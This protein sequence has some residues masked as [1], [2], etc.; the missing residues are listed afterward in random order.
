M[1]KITLLFLTALAICF[2]CY[3]LEISKIDPVLQN[4]IQLKSSDELIK[5]NI[6]MQAQ[7]DQLEL[8]SIAS[9]YRTKADKRS[10]VVNELKRYSQETQ[11]EV[12]SYLNHFANNKSVTEITQFWIFNGINCYATIEVIE[13]LSYL[14]DVL[15]I[16]LDKEQNLLP[17]YE[18][19]SIEEGGGRAIT[20]NVIKINAHL[21]WDLG[22]TGEGIIVAVLDSGVN[23]NHH[24]LRD[25]LWE[26]PNYP[27]AG[28]NYVGNNND[29]MDDHGHG[30]HCAGTVASDG[31][32]GTQAGVAPNAKIMA[33]KVMNASG[34]GNLS[35]ILSG[36]QFAVDQGADVISMSLGLSGGGDASTR[37]TFRNTMNNV[38]EAGIVAVVAAGN[39]GSFPGS[40]LYPVPNNIGA[41]A[42]CPPPWLHPDQTTTGGTSAVIAVGATNNNDAIASFSSKGPVTWQATTFADYPH[43][44]GMG[45]LRP[46][47]CAPGSSITSLQHTSNTGYVGG[48][49]WS[50]T[51]MAA[52]AVAGTIA[53]MLQKNQS[54][55][56]AEI[57]E[58]LETTAVSLPNATSP[59]GNTFGSGRIDAYEAVLAVSGCGGPISNLA[60]T[61]NY[62]KIV[63]ITWNRPANDDNLVGYNV[64][65]N[66]VLF[67]ELA[68]EESFIYQA[69]AEEEG[70]YIFCI[71]AVH[72]DNG[73]DCE[74]S[75]ICETINIVSICDP[76]TNLTANVGGNSVMLSWSAPELVSKVL[77]YNVFR[78]GEFVSSVQTVT[79]SENN[80]PS[81]NH[82]Y[83]V[84]AEYLN[85]CISNEVPVNVLVLVAPINLTAT[86]QQEE[87]KLTWEYESNSILFNV[88]RDAAKI[89]SHIAD[90][91]YTDTEVVEDVEYCYFIKA[92]IEGVESDP[93]TEACTK[94]IGIEEHSS[95]LKVYP[96]PSNTMIHVEGEGMEKITVFNSIGQIVKV[97]PATDTTTS[98]DVS[99]FA[100]GN[101]ILTVSYLDG[102]TGNVKVVVK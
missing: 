70:D 89:A 32:A 91:Q 98:I 78:N 10:F 27:N 24:D 47:V 44:P 13:A 48:S 99:K 60:Y 92:T 62:D 33:V 6:I 51:S 41:P 67:P 74:S 73:E 43:N 101:Y 87:I 64:Y 8:R 17:E 80:V 66:G 79:F 90:K 37:T 72:Q 75:K 21:V 30:T 18:Q 63:N 86:A 55:T 69:P 2:N 15:L 84:T 95:Y 50:G 68:T 19:L 83:A 36:I 71:A 26:H 102:S 100:P 39:D 61:L 58:I 81:G 38:L 52:P 5:I 93:S 28:W 3:C 35:H 29:P 76:I 97:V 16:G 7:Y 77:H 1:K 85:E 25:H 40:W 34:Q 96:N 12:M 20:D 94:I 56:P 42:N 82:T 53:L 49:T 46:D 65:I 59:K 57:C 14:D 54:L 9:M 4:E 22:Y 23:Y 88:Y 11:Q 31:S 45:L